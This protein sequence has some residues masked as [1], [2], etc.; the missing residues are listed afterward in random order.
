MT[1][2]LE[3]P[4]NE[5]WVPPTDRHNTSGQF[6]PAVHGFNGINFVS[7]AG[8]PQATDSRIIQTTVELREEFP[9][10]EDQNSGSP[11]GVGA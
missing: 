10:N 2:F 5:R 3:Q 9:F 4:Q 1:D 6:S 7:L 11:I 8:S